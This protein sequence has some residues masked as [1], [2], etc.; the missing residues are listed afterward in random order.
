MSRDDFNSTSGKTK[1]LGKIA[2]ASKSWETIFSFS[3]AAMVTPEEVKASNNSLRLL[4]NSNK[5][6]LSSN[7]RHLPRP[8]SNSLLATSRFRTG[9]TTFRFRS[10]NLLEPASPQPS[11]RGK[12]VFPAD[13]SFRSLR[14]N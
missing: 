8:S 10:I 2:L 3:A 6:L 11:D 14:R 13:G 7:S 1:T 5:R 4:N 9:T 12:N